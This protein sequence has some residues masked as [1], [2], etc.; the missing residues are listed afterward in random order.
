[1]KNSLS[2]KLRGIQIEKDGEK[3]KKVKKMLD[4]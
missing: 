4:I 2:G 3:I 1:M